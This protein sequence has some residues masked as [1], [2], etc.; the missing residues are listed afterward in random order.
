MLRGAAR[1]PVLLTGVLQ[2]GLM[3]FAVAL[4]VFYTVR[5]GR[6]FWYDEAMLVGAIRSDGLLPPWEPMSH[7]EQASP[8]GVYL[9]QKGALTLVGFQPDLLRIPGFIAYA[10]GGIAVWRAAASWFG[11]WAALLAGVAALASLD[12]VQSAGD[13]KHYIVEFAVSGLLL[14]FAA[15]LLRAPTLRRLVVLFAAAVVAIPFSNTVV[16]VVPGIALAIAVARVGRLRAVGAGT[17]VFFA[18]FAVW[19]LVA[20]R[21]STV[22]QLAY[23][24][25]RQ[26]STVDLY[27]SL[28][29]AVVQPSG[30]YVVS[31]TGFAVVGLVVALVWRRHL[32]PAFLPALVAV[33]LGWVAVRVGAVPFSADR[34]LLFLVPLI[35]LAVGAAAQAVAQVLLSAV[36][37]VARHSAAVVTVL[38]VVLA[39][40]A[41]ATIAPSAGLLRQQ[42]GQALAMH[43]SDCSSFYVDWWSQPMTVLYAE[44]LG[45]ADRVHGAVGT[46][47]GRGEDA[48]IYRVINAPQ[49]YQAGLVAWMRG[50]PSA[51]LVTVGGAS[52]PEVVFEPLTRAGL[53]CRELPAPVG[54]HLSRCSASA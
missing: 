6:D 2:A 5:T 10:L 43:A 36:P 13:F 3:L 40:G 17:A 11:G 15:R 20:I 24:S 4:T 49:Q 22:F 44:S 37:P 31:L 53:V 48:W 30:T 23:P 21:P 39:L 35:A 12:V 46:A 8:Y 52:E 18:A 27:T 26:S 38:G 14:W 19:Y 25:Y 28:V 47:S 50:H 1:S 33:L 42:T 51:C 7:F 45:L 16:F 29:R 34:H 32:V 9:I 41:T 54:I